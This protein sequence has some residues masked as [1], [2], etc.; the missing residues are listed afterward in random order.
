L[1]LEV[2]LIVK[3]AAPSLVFKKDD[4]NILFS[5]SFQNLISSDEGSEDSKGEHESLRDFYEDDTRP[6][7]FNIRYDSESGLLF[8]QIGENNN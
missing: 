2:P 4:N 5:V 7:K 8:L 3:E 1:I 6:S